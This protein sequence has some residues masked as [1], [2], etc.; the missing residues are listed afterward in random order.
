MPTFEETYPRHSFSELVRLA[1]ALAGL[2]RRCTHRGAAGVA[3][4]RSEQPE[5][6]D[7]PRAREA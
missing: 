5:A 1:L 3:P 2:I 4:A 7:R 6:A